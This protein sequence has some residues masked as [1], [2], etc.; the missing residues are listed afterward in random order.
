VPRRGSAPFRVG[1]R[2]LRSFFDGAVGKVAVY[3]KELPRKQVEE[4]NRVMTTR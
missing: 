4:H 1:T 3:T 2:D